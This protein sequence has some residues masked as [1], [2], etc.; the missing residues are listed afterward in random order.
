M[1]RAVAE[2]S[3]ASSTSL[4]ARAGKL[5]TRSRKNLSTTRLR[6]TVIYIGL[7]ACG[8]FSLLITVSIVGVLLGETLQ[9]FRFDEV[10]LANFLGSAEW[11]PLL[12]ATKSFGIWD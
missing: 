2:M 12:G 6:E 8:L 4:D 7:I 10:T 3:E 9:F 11:T 5:L 1:N